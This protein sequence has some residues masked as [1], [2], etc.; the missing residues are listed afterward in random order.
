MINQELSRIDRMLEIMA[1][2]D[3][4]MSHADLRR[5]TDSLRGLV[6]EA[7]EICVSFAAAMPA[8]DAKRF[9]DRIDQ[10]TPEMMARFVEKHL[11]KQIP[12]H[13]IKGADPERLKQ[14]IML[15]I[16]AIDEDID[17]DIA[18]QTA[19]SDVVDQFPEMHAPDFHRD[20]IETLMREALGLEGTPPA[21]EAAVTAQK[22]QAMRAVRLVTAAPLTYAAAEL[23][24]QPSF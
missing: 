18:I 3:V 11:D 21:L 6:E 7:R 16:Q 24:V 4:P 1:K 15:Q 22:V 8:L 9:A 13:A 14:Q 2:G 5:M 12:I 23:H 10:S 20:V 17:I 19:A